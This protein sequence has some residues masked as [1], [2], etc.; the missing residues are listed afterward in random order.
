MAREFGK[1]SY[2]PEN[3]AFWVNGLHG[4]NGE[5]EIYISRSLGK[6]IMLA[7]YR[8]PATAEE[9]AMEV[10]V[11]LTYAD[12]QAMVAVIEGKSADG[13]GAILKRL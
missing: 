9:L 6:N 5:P 8:T 2:K 12:G 7:E 10:G 3:I 13:D 1:L 4:T 11:A